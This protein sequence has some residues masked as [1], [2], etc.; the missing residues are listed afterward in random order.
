MATALGATFVAAVALAGCSSKPQDEATAK[1]KGP[2]PAK[3]GAPGAA[4][5]GGARP[6]PK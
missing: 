6:T 3:A 4:G 5:A 2:G 1:Y